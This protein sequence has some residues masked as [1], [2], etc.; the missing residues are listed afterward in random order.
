[1]DEMKWHQALEV[2]FSII[3]RPSFASGT[4]EPK[5]RDIYAVHTMEDI[6]KIY[7]N[8][9]Q[10]ESCIAWLIEAVKSA[11]V[12]NAPWMATTHIIDKLVTGLRAAGKHEDAKFWQSIHIP[13]GDG[14]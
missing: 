14:L 6:A 8:L 1:M 2:C 10:P 5:Y 13:D 11:F 4:I 3:G 7:G 12:L 9:G